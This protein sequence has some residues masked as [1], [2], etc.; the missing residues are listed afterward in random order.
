MAW[1]LCVSVTIVNFR[2]TCKKGLT[3]QDGVGQQT[4]VGHVTVY[5]TG[6]AHWC[7]MANASD[8]QR[9]DLSLPLLQQLIFSLLCAIGSVK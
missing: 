5:G 4:R 9:C 6:C 2:E 1:S 8:E 7:H 3:D